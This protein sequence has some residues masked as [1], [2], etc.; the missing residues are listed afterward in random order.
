MR[1]LRVWLN[2]RPVGLLAEANDVWHFTYDRQW[3][4]DALGFDLSPALPRALGTHT[5]GASER[6]VQWYFDN[7]LPEE[8]LRESL[9][10]DAGLA[11]ED[12]FGL[13]AWLG[14]ESAGSLVLQP[15]GDMLLDGGALRPLPDAALSQRIRRLPRAPLASGAPKRMSVAGAQHK[16]LVVLRDDGL[17]EPVGSEPSTHL[18]KPAHGDADYP[19]SVLNEYLVMQLAGAVGLNVPRVWR[20]HVPEPVYLVE[21]FDRVAGPHGV[22]RRHI[23]DAC[24]L[25]NRSRLFKYTAARLQTLAE[26]VVLCRNRAAAR[27]RLFRWLAFNVLVGNHDNHLKNLS[28]LVGPEGIELAPAYDL[29]S[30]AC[31]TTRALADERATWPQVPLAI[32]LPGAATFAAVTR[33]SLLDAGEVLG[34]PARSGARELDRLLRAC[35][36]ELP[37]LMARIEAENAERAATAPE[38]LA[39]ES[40]L[41]RTLAHI[42]L[43][44]M[45]ARLK[46]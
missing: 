14:A 19:A 29:L 2:D 28:F 13:L 9:A 6:P 22:Q 41:M 32:E 1:E 20:R 30:T 26:A 38:A 16:L 31:W 34:V 37:L 7:L 33:Q 24:Q 5:D 39:I 15:P 44:E 46:G 45:A 42:V 35:E 27:L 36:R 23:I 4:S 43:P 3:C 10:R 12:A 40:R 25:L 8:Q 18:L 17:H 11:G 21:R